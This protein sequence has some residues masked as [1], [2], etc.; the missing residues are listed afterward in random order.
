MC[1]NKILIG[2]L[3]QILFCYISDTRI[4]PEGLSFFQLKII[5]FGIKYYEPV[6]SVYARNTDKIRNKGICCLC[7]RIVSLPYRLFY[8]IY[9]LLFL[10]RFAVILICKRNSH[11]KLCK[12]SMQLIVKHFRTGFLPNRMVCCCSKHTDTIILIKHFSVLGHICI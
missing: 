6:L 12:G 3:I 2:K 7:F 5:I 9:Q 1:I 10:C 4:S 8:N 11:L